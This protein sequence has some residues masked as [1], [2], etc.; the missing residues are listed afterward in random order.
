MCWRDSLTRF[1]CFLV[2]FDGSYVLTPYETIRLL[3]K[4]CFRVKLTGQAHYASQRSEL[5]LWVHLGFIVRAQRQNI[6]LLVLQRKL[7][8]A[9]ETLRIQGYKEPRTGTVSTF[10][11]FPPKQYFHRWAN[12]IN[13]LT[14]KDFSIK[15]F[16]DQRSWKRLYIVKPL[17]D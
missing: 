15:K 2:P 11:N 1:A 12:L 16:T 10:K 9:P 14:R 13:S 4:F 7:M 3:F 17:M 8:R 5:T 6:F